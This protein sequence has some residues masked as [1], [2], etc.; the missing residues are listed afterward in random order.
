MIQKYG[1]ARWQGGLRDG[2]GTLSTETGSLRDQPYSFAKRFGDEKG[3]NPEEL[4]GAAHASCFAMQMSAFIEQSGTKAE[5]IEARST[6]TLT[7]GAEGADITRVHVE[8]VASVPGM[9][10]EQFQEIAERT[11]AGCPVSKVLKGADIT[12]AARLG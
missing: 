2:Q 12:M 7:V 1:E 8:V 5:S 9:T 3:T 11:K 4:I 6:V 10:A